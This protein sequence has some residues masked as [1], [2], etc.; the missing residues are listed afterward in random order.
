MLLAVTVVSGETSSG[1]WWAL[2]EAVLEKAHS[3]RMVRVESPSTAARSPRMPPT[4]SSLR[5]PP[6]RRRIRS[7]RAGP[8]VSPRHRC[9]L[10]T[11]VSPHMLF[12][13]SLVLDPGEELRFTIVDARSVVLTVDGRSSARSEVGDQVCARV[14]RSPHGSSPSVRGTSTRS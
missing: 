5:P 9:L 8:I 1:V 13:R 11:P 4:A 3:G 7:P 2:N 10:L 12:D 6:A 14:A